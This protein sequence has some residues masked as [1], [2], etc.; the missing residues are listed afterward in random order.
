MGRWHVKWIEMGA[1]ISRWLLR[2]TRTGQVIASW[3]GTGVGD[4][5]GSQD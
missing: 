4:G 2:V 1:Y 3:S 5:W